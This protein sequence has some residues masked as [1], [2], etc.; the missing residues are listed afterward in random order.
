MKKKYTV[1]QFVELCSARKPSVYIY[2][3]GNQSSRINQLL[4]MQAELSF[5]EMIVPVPLAGKGDRLY[6]K[7]G[8]D[9]LGFNRIRYIECDINEEMIGLYFT[10]VC[11]SQEPN[12]TDNRYVMLAD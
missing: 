6:F 12:A 7:N 8:K 5:P 11:E 10:I 9:Y 1:S 3:S 2:Q 4:A